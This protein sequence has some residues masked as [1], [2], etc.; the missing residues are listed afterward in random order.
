[1]TVPR[2]SLF[3]LDTGP[4]ITL[5]AADKLDYLLYPNVPVVIPDAVFYEA[6][7]DIAKLGAQSILDWVKAH[8][9]QVEIAVTNTYV[10]FDA[11]RSVNPRAYEPHLAEHAAVEIIEEPTRLQ[12]DD[13]A[14]LLCEESAVTRRVIVRERERIIELSTMDFLRIL[15]AEQRIQSAD[16]VF[17]RAIAAGRTPSREEK[18]GEYDPALREAVRETLRAARR[19]TGNDKG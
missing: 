17:D 9:T 13:R 3:I 11:A 10:N 18:L 4:L 14:V 19:P 1:M 16:A 5:A 12:G 15:E 8:H 6:T 2:V 7:R